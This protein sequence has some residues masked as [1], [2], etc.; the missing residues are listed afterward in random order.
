[1]NLTITTGALA[2]DGGS[3][4]L[5]GTDATGAPLHILLDWS[6]VSARK[7]NRKLTINDAIVPIGSAAETDWLTALENATIAPAVASLV[8]ALITNVR[9]PAYQAP[10]QPQ[11]SLDDELRELLAAGKKSEAIKAYRRAHPAVGLAEANAAIN[12][13][14]NR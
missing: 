10:A 4:A 6:I 2:T 3:I 8:T 1:M 11:R 9:S 7:N 14:T 5:S 13:I 12:A